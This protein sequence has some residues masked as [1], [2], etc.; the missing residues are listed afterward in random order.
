MGAVFKELFKVKII[1]DLDH[2]VGEQ[3]ACHYAE[4]CPEITAADH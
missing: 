2:A 1:Y 4:Y 3:G